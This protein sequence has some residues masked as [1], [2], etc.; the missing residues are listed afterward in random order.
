MTDILKQWQYT[1]FFTLH[2]HIIKHDTLLSKVEEKLSWRNGT[3]PEI[4]KASENVSTRIALLKI[5]V[6]CIIIGVVTTLPINP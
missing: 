4:P 3:V 2:N 5:D 1:F 6:V